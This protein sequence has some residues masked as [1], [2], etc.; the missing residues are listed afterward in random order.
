LL[1]GLKTSFEAFVTVTDPAAS[2]RLSSYKKLLPQMEANLPLPDEV[3]TT[4]GGESPIRVVDLL[5]SS[6]DARRSVQ[7]IA[8]N[9]P[10]DERVRAEKGAKKVLLRNVIETK[11]D[12]IMRPIAERILDPS[13]LHLLSADAFFQH[14]LLHEL[15]HSLGPAF[16]AGSGNQVEVRRALEATYS[17]I[18]E[19]KAD[20]MGAYNVLFLIHRGEFPFDLRDKMLVSYFAGLFR[21]TRFGVGE[22]H[23]QG[24]A[25][26]I[27]RYLEANAV[28]FD[29]T[30]RQFKVD[31]PRLEAAITALLRE[32]CLLQHRGDKPAADAML[33][34]DGVVSEP[35]KLA[36]D[37]LEGVPI[38]IRPSYPIENELT[39]A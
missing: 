17:T 31:L 11:F 38:D 35:M 29:R 25:L 36:L 24:A 28:R 8:F 7:T 2:E 9:L 1:L 34:K 5:Y 30:T 18:E 15:S 16:V 19:A 23:G 10:N 26:Q 32:I 20:V 37:T 12:R 13:Q 22:A 39:G 3:K 4:R 21:S 33:A 27:N 6:G 14:T